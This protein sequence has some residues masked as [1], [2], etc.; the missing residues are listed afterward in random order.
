MRALIDLRA[1]QHFVLAAEEL[2]FARAAARAHISQTPFGRS[3]QALEDV[4]GQRLFD[5][6]TR[7]VRLTAVGDDVE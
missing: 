6:T 5:R 4:L 3:I 7:S 1:L 2:N